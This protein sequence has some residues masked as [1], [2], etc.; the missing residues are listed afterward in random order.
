[1]EKFKQLTEKYLLPLL[2][3]LIP[4]AP[5]L[6]EKFFTEQSTQFLYEKKYAKNPLEE[7]NRAV[8]K[9]TKSLEPSDLKV[10]P[11]PP[12]LLRSIGKEIGKSMPAMLAGM[13]FKPFDSLTVSIYNQSDRDLL[14]TRVNFM[15][16]KNHFEILTLP[17][18]TGS[19]GNSMLKDHGSDE[20]IT[21]NYGRIAR[22]NVQSYMAEIVYY[23]EDAS[24]C[25]IT[26]D[27]DRDNGVAARGEEVRS[28]QDR[29]NQ[30]YADSSER[31][32]YFE[33]A[34]KLV[35]SVCIIY[36]II[37]LRKQRS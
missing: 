9:F 8:E 19:V 28:I 24:K 37:S 1:M 29:V 15:G 30:S 5:G 35:V 12:P 13:G 32:K 4:F 21:I 26:V 18:A 10:S 22:R 2:L 36:L 31:S 25:V 6:Y 7:W 20:A 33:L 27:A 14:N 16:C 34:W 3:A 11:A 23:G 17:D